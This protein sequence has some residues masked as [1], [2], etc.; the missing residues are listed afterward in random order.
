MKLC[1][2]LLTMAC[3]VA[4]SVSPSAA[5]DEP[6]EEEL[7]QAR[8]DAIRG[9][10]ATYDGE[11]RLENGHVDIQRLVREVQ[12]LSCNSY[13]FLVWH[14]ETDWED[15]HV[16]LGETADSGLKVWVSLVPPSESR[17]KKSEPFGLDYV[18]WARAI[19]QLSAQHPHLIAWSI[20]DFTHNLGFYTPEYLQ[21]MMDAA[22][23][24]NP[25]LA[26]VPCTYFPAA[27][28]DFADGYREIL[29]GLLFYYRHESAGANLTDPSLCPDEIATLR[30]RFGEGFPIILG[31]Y[32][33]GHSRLGKTTPEYVEE[34]MTCGH[35]LADGVHVYC[36]QEPDTPKYE[37]VQRLFG[38]WIAG[39]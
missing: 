16:F 14:A 32:A 10:L 26:F 37:V 36:H 13:D 2:L 29:D 15:L 3:I 30:E 28:Q 20:D 25:R 21:Q 5:Q 9:T 35:E 11:P 12:E 24:H 34:V 4:L 38:Q 39:E 1:V 7:R 17:S 27:T 31:L 19:G 22:H 8:Q 18:Q 23:E 6:T 33:S